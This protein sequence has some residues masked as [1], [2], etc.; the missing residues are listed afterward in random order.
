MKLAKGAV[1]E[2]L[3]PSHYQ[4]LSNSTS[5]CLS[6]KILESK[7]F[8]IYPKFPAIINGFVILNIL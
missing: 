4:W 8:Y 5:F 1:C 3:S 7:K 6:V 2:S